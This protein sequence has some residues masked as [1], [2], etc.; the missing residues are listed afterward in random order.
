MGTNTTGNRELDQMGKALFGA[1]FLGSFPQDAL[2]SAIFKKDNKK[3]YAII[4]VDTTGMPG[5]HWVA[6][7]GLPNSNK[8]MVFD[9]FGRATKDLLPIIHQQVKKS[10]SSF[11]DTDYDAEQKKIQKSCGQYSLSWLLFFDKY[12]HENAALI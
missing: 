11:S 9:S 4:N 1:K 12:G 8:I 10:G 6:I 3:R 2:P 5:T 7:A